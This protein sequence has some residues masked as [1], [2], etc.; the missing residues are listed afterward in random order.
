[1]SKEIIERVGQPAQKDY[2]KGDEMYVQISGKPIEKKCPRCRHGY[3]NKMTE[4]EKEK[5]NLDFTENIFGCDECKYYEELSY[6]NK[7]ILSNGF[8][9]IN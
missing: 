6:D 9:K 8:V 1:M 3:L 7:E 4:D 5:C 2:K